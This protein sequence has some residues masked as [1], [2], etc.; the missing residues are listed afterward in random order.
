MPPCNR[1]RGLRQLPCTVAC[2]AVVS[3]GVLTAQPVPVSNLE[4]LQLRPNFYMIAGAG[5]NIGFQIGVDG[6]VVVDAGTASSADAVVAAIKKVTAKPIRYIINTSADRDH[7]GGNAIVAKAGQTLFTGSGGAGL[8]TNFLGGGASI[9]SVEQ[10]LTRMSGPSGRPSPFPVEAWPTETFNIPR[11]Y[12]YLNGEG[13]E[14]FHEPAA[15][16]DGDAIV[17]FRRS[18]VVVA[19]DVLD[20]RR[21]PVIDVAE[22]GSI[23]GEIAALQKLVDTAIPSGPIVSRE[24]GTLII[25]GHGRI[26]D[27]LDVVEYRDMVTII[28]DRVRDLMKQGLTLEQIKAASPARGYIRRYGSDTGS[29]T[30]N[31]F[32]EAI[33]RGLKETAP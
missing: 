32:M 19:G 31:D 16:S 8:A 29:W 27:Q 1:V 13:I 17:F 9:L 10:V 3:V 33:Y 24:E 28:R 12:V 7:V 5:G 30:T 18:D 21:F 6:V 26:C 2:A 23:Q 14:I 11:K 20:T 25:P 4:V 22:G 15:H